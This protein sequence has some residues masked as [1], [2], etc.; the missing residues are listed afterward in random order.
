MTWFTTRHSDK[1]NETTLDSVVVN[2]NKVAYDVT[3]YK[4]ANNSAMN[5][6]ELMASTN[7][8]AL[9]SDAF[10][11][12][13]YGN[14]TYMF[15]NTVDESFV[16]SAGKDSIV[17]R[18]LLYARKAMPISVWCMIIIKAFAAPSRQVPWFQIRKGQL[19]KVTSRVDARALLYQWGYTAKDKILQH[20]EY[21]VFDFSVG[22]SIK[23]YR[24]GVTVSNL[25]NENYTEKDGYNM[26]GRMLMASYSYSF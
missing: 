10:K 2:Q 1:I 4:N 15:N 21:L 18:D 23:S 12:E 5:G 24:F 6:V 3:T 20:P 17:S 26:P 22:Y 25:L 9:F 11:L 13:L 14:W 19:L 8:G 16:S 7:I